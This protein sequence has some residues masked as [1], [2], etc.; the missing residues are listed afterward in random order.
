M[1]SFYQ[2]WGDLILSIGIDILSGHVI[3]TKQELMKRK[4]FRRESCEMVIFSTIFRFIY[5]YLLFIHNVL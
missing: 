4:I 3:K 1:I 5:I 2:Y